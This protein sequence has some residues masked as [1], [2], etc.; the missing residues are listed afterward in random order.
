M[1]V[2]LEVKDV[3]NHHR[4]FVIARLLFG[5]MKYY[6]SYS[7]YKKALSILDKIESAIIRDTRKE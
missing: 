4:R 7:S 3:P 1:Q 5:E 6:S 2:A